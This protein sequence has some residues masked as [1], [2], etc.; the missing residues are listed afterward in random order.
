M[1]FVQGAGD[2]GSR[3]GKMKRNTSLARQR[4]PLTS[5]VSRGGVEGEG[6]AR[7]PRCGRGQRHGEHAA[8]DGLLL[9]HLGA[10]AVA[11]GQSPVESVVCTVGG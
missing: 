7:G 1:F 11:V 5:D 6:C 8:R 4:K 3:Q 2:L 10:R 9:E